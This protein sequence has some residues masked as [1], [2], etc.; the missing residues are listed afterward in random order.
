MK[1]TFH[2]GAREVG[3]SCIVVETDDAKVA[4]DYGMKVEEGIS[5]SLPKDLDAAIISHAHLDHSG[6]LLNLAKTNTVVVGSEATR[7][8][9]I[10]LL[11]DLIK[12]QRM[13]GKSA[14]YSQSDV[15]KIRKLWWARDSIALPGMEIRLYPAGHVLGANMIGV[16]VKEKEILYTGDFCLHDTEILEGSNLIKLPKQ[17]EALIVESTYGGKTRLNRSELL[18]RLFAKINEAIDRNGNVL[19]PVF[20]FHRSQEMAKRIDQAMQKGVLPNYNAYTISK[21]A[22]K[23][24][25]Y[26]NCYKELLSEE[27]REQEEP[28]N[29]KHVKHLHRLEQI[30]EPAIVIC[31]S[32]FGLAGASRRLLAD[33]ASNKN[34]SVIINSGYIPPES[35]FTMIKEEGELIE[36]GVK[37]PVKADVEQIDLSG[38]ADQAELVKLVKILKPNQTFLVH[39]D[40]E[41]ARALS[42]KINMITNVEIPEKKETVIMKV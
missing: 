13:N 32:G 19:I 20:A 6:N 4:L 17:P 11:R 37:V 38:H 35:P 27:I 24:T 2:G 21:L 22:Q 40:L 31:T 1:I 8:I 18:E 41:Q 42:T 28:F 9:T 26:F 36:N 34:D 30:V 14:P 25:G 16:K 12:V 29:Y 7:D 15:A 33:W 23:I 10:E 3:G 39:G 5:D